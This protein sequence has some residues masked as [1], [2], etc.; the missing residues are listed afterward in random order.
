MNIND[1]QTHPFT[2][3]GEDWALLT[4]GTKDEFNSMTIS[5]GGMGTLWGTSVAFIF[6]KPTRYT[7]EFIN[8]HDEITISFYTPEI[9]KK[10][11]TIFGSKSGRDIDKPKVAGLT[12]KILDNGVT[13]EEAT[14]TIVCKKLFMQQL[15]KE[16]FPQ[17]ALPYYNGRGEKE[18]A[19]HY[20]IVA[21]VTNILD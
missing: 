13:Y 20:F 17:I 16:K 11:L 18:L 14:E 1:Y 9:K 15:D 3:F 19:A 7:Y 10:S 6:V 21:E 8:R 4:A 5:W 12:P 2:K